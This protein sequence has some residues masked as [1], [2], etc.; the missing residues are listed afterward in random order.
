MGWWLGRAQQLGHSGSWHEEQQ[1]CALCVQHVQHADV[2]RVQHSAARHAHL[3]AQR[4]PS[5]QESRVNHRPRAQ[6]PAAA[7]R[8]VR[9]APDLFVKGQASQEAA[10]AFGQASLGGQQVSCKRLLGGSS[11]GSASALPSLRGQ[12]TPPD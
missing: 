7:R 2:A 9:R 4:V 10:A 1:L 11:T 5:Q 6:Q 8:R 3:R 12:G